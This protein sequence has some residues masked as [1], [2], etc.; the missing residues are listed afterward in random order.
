MLNRD[1]ADVSG[2]HRVWPQA[3]RS[4]AWRCVAL[5]KCVAACAAMLLQIGCIYIDAEAK[6]I[7]TRLDGDQLTV[8]LLTYTASGLGIA[9]SGESYSNYQTFR[10]HYR[11]DPQG[12]ENAQ[13]LW[14]Q[15]TERIAFPEHD[16]IPQGG[17]SRAA[18]KQETDKT[19]YY[20]IEVESTEYLISGY[21]KRADGWYRIY[22]E[23]FLLPSKM[24]VELN[25]A[26]VGPDD[27][28]VTR[29]LVPC[30]SA[31]AG[32]T[33]SHPEFGAWDA[34][35][36]VVAMWGHNMYRLRHEYYDLYNP[37]TFRCVIV[38]YEAKTYQTYNLKVDLK[39][40]RALPSLREDK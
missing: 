37:S 28:V 25:L 16:S 35:R 40:L 23:F 39:S 10:L 12:G 18:F 15:M 24:P 33:S 26:V 17:A 20:T 38:N 13:L 30:R 3:G 32:F 36:P 27:S 14:P 2:V 34:T 6:V 1:N 31:A 5:L 9:H 29:M 22:S 8:D 21:G 19:D 11:L 7:E 4:R